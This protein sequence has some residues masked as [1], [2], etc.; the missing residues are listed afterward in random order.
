MATAKE[1]KIDIVENDG[2]LYEIG[3]V[4]GGQVPQFLKGKYTSRTIAQQKINQY[5]AT[6]KRGAKP[7]GKTTG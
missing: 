6:E 1:F 5:L 4:G 3:F 2:S 7:N